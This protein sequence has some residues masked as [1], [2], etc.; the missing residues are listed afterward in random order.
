MEL[1]KWAAEENLSQI[2]H[3]IIISPAVRNQ[4]AHCYFTHYIIMDN[5]KSAKLFDG[6]FFAEV[7]L[8]V[9]ET[10]PLVCRIRPED[11]QY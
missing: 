3:L 7:R 6:R 10:R 1:E 5:K 9:L 8:E 2:V 11:V 4:P